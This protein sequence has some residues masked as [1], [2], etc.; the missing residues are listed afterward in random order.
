MSELTN[1]FGSLAELVQEKSKEPDFADMA[2]ESGIS[3]EGLMQL[4]STLQSI[5]K[6][7]NI[8]PTF[9]EYVRIDMGKL[10]V[11]KSFLRHMELIAKFADVSM[12]SVWQLLMIETCQMYAD[13]YAGVMEIINKELTTEREA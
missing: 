2:A 12:E 6:N 4:T 13:K 10:T 3:H 8:V 1:K 9:P 11:P 5:N 7:K